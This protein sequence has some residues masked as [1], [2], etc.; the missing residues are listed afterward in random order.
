MSINYGRIEIP[1]FLKIQVH[2][3]VSNFETVTNTVFVKK[4]FVAHTWPYLWLSISNQ[5][6]Q[7]IQ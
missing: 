6:A 1:Q 2:L 5:G 7:R 4:S 3:K